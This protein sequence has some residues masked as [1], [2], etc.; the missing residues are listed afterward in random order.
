VF[1]LLPYISTNIQS[2]LQSL[3]QAPS[4][5]VDA[6]ALDQVL[7]ILGGELTHCAALSEHSDT[8]ESVSMAVE[9]M[10]R[11]L[12]HECHLG[13]GICR[14]GGAGIGVLR[15]GPVEE[16]LVSRARNEV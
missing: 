9:R 13:C 7:I 14:R 3:D 11:A 15:L 6:W 5:Y 16:R 2:V 10:K 8:W 4:D 12:E 1:T